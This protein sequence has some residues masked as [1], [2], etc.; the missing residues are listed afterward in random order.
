MEPYAE[1]VKELAAAQAKVK[2]EREKLYKKVISEIKPGTLGLRHDDL[3]IFELRRKGRYDSL[4]AFP[5]FTLNTGR[6]DTYG[7]VNYRKDRSMS[8][9]IE[10]NI[11]NFD[12]YE[13]IEDPLVV[14]KLIQDRSKL[15][16]EKAKQFA[17]R[18]Y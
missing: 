15:E 7:S 1:A 9:F 6:D 4:V 17:S 18:S 11:D 5:V 3:F 8:P 13:T 2:A 10:I 12:Q 16:V 14:I